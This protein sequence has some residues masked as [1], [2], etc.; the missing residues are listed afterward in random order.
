MGLFSKE[1]ASLPPTIPTIFR[2]CLGNIY[3]K[4]GLTTQAMYC[5]NVILKGKGKN[6]ANTLVSVGNV[7]L[8]NVQRALASNDDGSAR[9]HQQKALLFFRKVSN[10]L[11]LQWKLIPSSWQ[12]LERNPRNMWAANGIGATLSSRNRK[13]AGEVVF[14]Q[15]AEAGKECPSAILNSAHMALEL[16]KHQE[17][18]E[19]YKQCLQPNS[20][21]HNSV[22]VML[23]LAKA[24][25]LGGNATESKL[26]LSKARHLDPHNPVLMYNL[27]LA[28]QEE[29]EQ[30]L[31]RPRVKS[32][33]LIKA[34]LELEVAFG[35][36][37]YKL[38]LNRISI[39]NIFVI[40]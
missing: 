1:I 32:V 10:I 17:A 23:G 3:I 11:C 15:I 24:L 28:I 35:W 25:Y 26:W 13:S 27:G 7:C 21:H 4:T 37:K 2:T 14:K 9:R 39:N 22:E 5:L 36:T 29:S 18:I 34:E 19:A 12:A 20:L 40:F 8:K 30:I 6:D 16:G 33:I 31:A 38:C